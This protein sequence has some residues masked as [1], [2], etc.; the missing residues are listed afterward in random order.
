M[1]T[2]SFFRY[3]GGKSKLRKEILPHI[4]PHLE[5]REPFVGGGHIA[6][7]VSNNVRWI[8]DWDIGIVALWKAVFFH[9]DALCDRISAFTP[10]VDEFFSF[11]EELRA[12]D[13]EPDNPVDIGFKK[14]AIHQMSFSGL[15]V[16]AGGPIGGIDQEGKTYQIGCRWNPKLL[17][18]KIR[19]ISNTQRSIKVTRQDFSTLIVDVTN[20][21]VLYV[22]PPYYVQGNVL[23][24]H[25]FSQEQHEQLA[26]LLKYTRHKWVLSYDDCQEIRDLYSWANITE[27]NISYTISGARKSSELL[28][29]P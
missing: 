13:V 4:D 28:I 7:S 11:K 10:S 22:D 21:A 5:Y 23:Y 26:S 3:P 25:G 20:D 9:T 8:N 15:G 12:C 16:M 29:F 14:L 1:T 24:Q 18:K 6:L 19:A 2:H 27:V 17:M